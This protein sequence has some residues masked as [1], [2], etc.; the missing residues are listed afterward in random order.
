MANPTWFTKDPTR[1]W[2]FYGHRLNLYRETIPHQGFAILKKWADTKNAF[3][4][5]SNVDGQFQKAGFAEEHIC[6]CHGSIHWLQH[7]HPSNEGEEIWSA[8]QTQIDIDTEQVRAVGILPQKNG[9]LVRPNILMFG[10]YY[11][12]GDR[13]D[14]QY[15]KMQEWA[16][17]VDASKLVII[18]IGAGTAIPSVRN[19]SSRLQRAGGTLIRINPRESQGA[20]I[21]FAC[22]GKQALIA[23]EEKLKTL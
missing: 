14:A 7:L 1:A 13:T 18:E 12:L 19:Q 16:N 3:V 21:P 22:G 6:E 10:D 15:E 17:K 20:D 4:Y 23:I 8:D 9:T 11:W 2:G 5:T